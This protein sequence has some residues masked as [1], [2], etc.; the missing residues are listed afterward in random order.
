MR[1]TRKLSIILLCCGLIQSI[2]FGIWFAFRTSRSDVLA[3]ATAL[4]LQGPEG[5]APFIGVKFSPRFGIVAE[6]RLMQVD[7]SIPLS[8]RASW[9]LLP[10]KAGIRVVHHS[11]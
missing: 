4:K 6:Y 2:A 9:Y 3:S 5:D 8:N 10:D 7:E 1:F 11:R